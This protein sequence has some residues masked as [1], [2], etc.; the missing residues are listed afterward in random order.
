MDFPMLTLSLIQFFLIL[1]VPSQFSSFDFPFYCS[2]CLPCVGMLKATQV[3]KESFQ[4]MS[5]KLPWPLASLY[6]PLVVDSSSLSATLEFRHKEWFKNLRLGCNWDPSNI[7]LEWWLEV[8]DSWKKLEI[9]CWKN[10]NALTA[11][12]LPIVSEWLTATFV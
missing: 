12:Y 2:C 4:K 7:W 5:F 6:L 10:L 1:L 9:C 11:L 3:P 8:P